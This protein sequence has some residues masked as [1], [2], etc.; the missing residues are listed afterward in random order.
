MSRKTSNETAVPAKRRAATEF[1]LTLKERA[2]LADPNWLSEDD[3][4]AIVCA[5]RANE[6]A[7]PLRKI[8]K[9]RGFPSGY[10]LDR[11]AAPKR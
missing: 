10:P 11:R 6:P 8:L 3:A 5:R 1:T 9:D 4:D 2:M 7:I